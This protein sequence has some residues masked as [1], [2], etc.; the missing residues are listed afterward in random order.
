MPHVA[1]TTTPLFK[2][3]GP[4]LDV[5]RQ[6][7]F[8]IVYPP[9]PELAT[10]AETADALVQAD[11]VLAGSDVYSDGALARLP[12]L[13]V[14]S[15]M[16]VGFDRID[17]A[18]ATRRGVAV[19]ITPTANHESVAEHTWALI[20]A[21]ARE[22]GENDRQ[23][24]SGTWQRKPLFPLRDRTLGLIGLGRIGRSVAVR[25]G[26][27]R[28]KVIAYDPIIKPE[29]AAP[30]GITLVPLPE[31]L[32]RSD[33]VSL[34]LPMSDET[35]GL[36][37]RHTLAQMKPGSFLINTARG[38]LVVEEDL[39]EA[40]RSG[41]LA[42]AGLD[43]LAKEPPP[44]DHPFFSLPNVILTSHNAG[45]DS[46][47]ILDSSLAAAQNIVDL[48][49]GRWPAESMVNPAVKDCWKWPK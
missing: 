12:K 49:Q 17:V 20:L 22:L 8:E 7:G 31:L 40:L 24:R 47:S 2:Q 3:P 35:R 25:A 37:C 26:G 4:H 38:G 46:Q 23:I 45:G 5:L 14:I 28:M 1:I 42:G 10:E 44:K 13:K 30:L 15:R 48:Y 39:L 32:S 27:F 34:H 6:A 41:H 33:F 18:A 11:A 19:T 16:G 43:V 29:S 36:I 9:H 21:I